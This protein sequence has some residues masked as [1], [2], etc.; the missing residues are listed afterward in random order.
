MSARCNLKKV[1]YGK[2]LCLLYKSTKKYQIFSLNFIDI[3]SI[4]HEMTCGVL[5]YI[6]LKL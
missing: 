2:W 1:D 3:Q 6:L 4:H 5:D